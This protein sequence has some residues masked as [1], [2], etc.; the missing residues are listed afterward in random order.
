[1]TM[2]SAHRDLPRGLV[3][4]GIGI[5]TLL[6]L[7]VL[8]IRIVTADPAPLLPNILAGLA[9]AALQLV[10]AGL[11]ARSLRTGDRR[12]LAAATGLLIVGSIPMFTFAPVAL[13]VLVLWAQAWSR[14]PAAGPRRVPASAGL[15]LLAAAGAVAALFVHVDPYCWERT[16]TADD[17]T[18]TR[19]VATDAPS[20]F[21]WTVDTTTTSGSS[22]SADSD[23]VAA[24][25]SSDRIVPAEALTSLLLT[26]AAAWAA[27]RASGPA[28]RGGL[29]SGR[30]S[31]DAG[32]GQGGFS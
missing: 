24:G 23:V 16:R 9:L 15:A 4:A 32:A 30:R 17:G 27:T 14:W 1:M 28:S 21:R 20:G 10:P 11:A 6:G 5:A 22:I 25:C 3:L 7:G 18:T 19:P 29:K 12:G 13:L 26:G 31:T 2:S 8:V